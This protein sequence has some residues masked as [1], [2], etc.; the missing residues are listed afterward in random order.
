MLVSLVF[1]LYIKIGKEDYLSMSIGKYKKII[2]IGTNKLKEEHNA[3]GGLYFI[4]VNILMAFILVISLHLSWS[5]QAVSMADN[6]SY[7]VSINCTVH[8]YVGKQPAY[9]K[10]NPVIS[11]QG[12]G[13]YNPLA[14][15]NK[16]ASD[17]GIAKEPASE[18][19]VS[20]DG[21]RTTVQVGSFKTSLGDNVR[22]HV[23]NSTIENY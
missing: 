23:Q 8:N 19:K 12:S 18:I 20:W 11:K 1:S 14:D 3:M 17:A 6:L 22:P 15:F 10:T 7:L 9:N 13:N 21:K 5:S 16:M 4:S 2:E